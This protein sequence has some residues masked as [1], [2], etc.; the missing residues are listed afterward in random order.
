MVIF[1]KSLQPLRSVRHCG[2]NVQ[3]GFVE[4]P[5]EIDRFLGTA[6]QSGRNR[7]DDCGAA[8]ADIPLSALEGRGGREFF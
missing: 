4:L 7:K 3:A 1:Q 5:C 8:V 2:V 6:T